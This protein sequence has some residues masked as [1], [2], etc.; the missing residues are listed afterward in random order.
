MSCGVG[1]RHSSDP[2]LA[3]AALIQPLAWAL[4][5]AMGAALKSK[6]KQINKPKKCLSV[7]ID[8]SVS[9][10]D[11]ENENRNEFQFW[12]IIIVL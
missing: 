9:F 4:P 7:H 11:A 2:R 12:F 1:H 3:A 5:Y 10:A 6:N 8:L